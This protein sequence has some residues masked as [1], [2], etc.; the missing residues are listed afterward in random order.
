MVDRD[1]LELFLEKVP[2]LRT[3][4]G[5]LLTVVYAITCGLGCVLYC[6]LID[7]MGP[8]APILSQLLM[9]LFVGIIGYLHFDWAIYYHTQYEELAY[10]HFFYHL[11]LPYVITWSACVFHPLFIDGPQLLPQVWSIV[12]GAALILLAAL[13]SV[14]IQRAGFYM[15]THGMDVFTVYPDEAAAVRGAIYGYVRHP[16]YLALICLGLGVGLLRNNWIALLAA[17]LVLIP[18]L[19]IAMVEDDELI[20][21]FGEAHMAYINRTAT[22]FPHKRMGRFLLLLFFLSSE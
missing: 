9:V 10:R 16:L 2:D 12:V 20:D 7:Q 19:A 17:S 11:M 15:I 6:W 14:H 1:A 18:A 5:V 8:Q 21:R 3:A 22:L 13:I 4:R